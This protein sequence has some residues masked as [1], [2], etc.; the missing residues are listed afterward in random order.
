MKR[1]FSGC[2]SAQKMQEILSAK[3][4]SKKMNSL[5]DV[6]GKVLNEGSINMPENLPDG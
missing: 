4:T 5:W 6:V 3:S 1:L 2:S